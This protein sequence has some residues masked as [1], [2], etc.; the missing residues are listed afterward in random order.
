[1]EKKGPPGSTAS[2]RVLALV[3]LQGKPQPIEMDLNRTA[4]MVIDM[5]NGHVSKGSFFDLRGVKTKEG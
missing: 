5:Q 2:A 4:V 1:M 3:K